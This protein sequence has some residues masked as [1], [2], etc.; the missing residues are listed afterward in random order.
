MVLGGVE[1]PLPR[2]LA[3][4][5]RQHPFLELVFGSACKRGVLPI[6]YRTLKNK[7]KIS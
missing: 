4:P 6:D 7:K 1:P 3:F 5:L 2:F